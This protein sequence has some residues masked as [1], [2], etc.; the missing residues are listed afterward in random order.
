MNQ[1]RWILDNPE[2]AGELQRQRQ[3]MFV[4][5]ALLTIAGIALM[6]VPAGVLPLF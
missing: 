5:G 6:L 4:L 2:R 3:G 1:L